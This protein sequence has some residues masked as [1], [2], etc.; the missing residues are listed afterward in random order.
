MTALHQADSPE[1]YDGSVHSVFGRFMRALDG[2]GD[3]DLPVGSYAISTT[4]LVSRRVPQFVFMSELTP[5]DHVGYSIRV[6][7]IEEKERDRY[8]R[9]LETWQSDPR[10]AF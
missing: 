8:H 4:L 10:A 3:V 5:I 7:R 2:S 1:N 6:Y 9:W